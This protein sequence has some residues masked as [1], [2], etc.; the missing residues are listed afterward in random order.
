MI[1]PSFFNDDYFDELFNTAR[2]RET[3]KPLMRTDVKEIGA[4][5]LLEIE[6]PGLRR[7]R[8]MQSWRRDT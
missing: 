1:V 2:G 8:S 6:M 3:V 7:M 4:D 5:Y